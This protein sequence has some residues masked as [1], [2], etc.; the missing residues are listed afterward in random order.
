MITNYIASNYIVTILCDISNIALLKA[1]TYTSYCPNGYNE[2]TITT[3]YFNSFNKYSLYY[4]SLFNNY[5]HL[6]WPRLVNRSD[7]YSY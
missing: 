4:Q 1:T 3:S 5:Q 6:L 2:S 7:N